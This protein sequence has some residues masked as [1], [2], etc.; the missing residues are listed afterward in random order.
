MVVKIQ[1]YVDA[2][3]QIGLE[4]DIFYLSSRCFG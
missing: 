2:P 1:G 4:S 3:N